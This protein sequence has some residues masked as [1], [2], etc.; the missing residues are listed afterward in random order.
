MLSFNIPIFKGDTKIEF[1]EPTGCTLYSSCKA[2]LKTLEG[3]FCNICYEICQKAKYP[4]I[5]TLFHNPLDQCV[6]VHDG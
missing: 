6:C 2:I 3:S 1:Q 4:I 5:K